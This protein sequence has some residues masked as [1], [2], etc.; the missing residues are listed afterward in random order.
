MAGSPNA[1][2]DRN[3][4]LGVEA[5]QLGGLKGLELL[6]VHGARFLRNSAIAVAS[7][8]SLGGSG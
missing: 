3:S 6:A 5:V 2:F 8:L 4:L 1:A 7:S